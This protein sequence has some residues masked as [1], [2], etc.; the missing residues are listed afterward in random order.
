MR[1]VF[2]LSPNQYSLHG[3]ERGTQKKNKIKVE[4]KRGGNEPTK[5]EGE[6][7]GRAKIK[8]LPCPVQHLPQ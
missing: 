1:Y 6:E 5:E 8:I 7:G 2:D 3:E 4:I